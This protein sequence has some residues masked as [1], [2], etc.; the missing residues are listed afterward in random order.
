MKVHAILREIYDL[1]EQITEMTPGYEKVDAF[2][3]S[4][5]AFIIKLTSDIFGYE[6]PVEQFIAKFKVNSGDT[7]GWAIILSRHL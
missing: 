2:F 4:K 5:N 3:N 1:P 7:I 6:L